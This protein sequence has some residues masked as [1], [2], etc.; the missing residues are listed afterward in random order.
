LK[1]LDAKV[2]K[3]TTRLKGSDG[4]LQLL[5]SKMRK[6]YKD[7]NKKICQLEEKFRKMRFGS[8][9]NAKDREIKRLKAQI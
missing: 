7:F 6:Y 5:S 9:S 3:I 8:E 4:K 2:D 1:N